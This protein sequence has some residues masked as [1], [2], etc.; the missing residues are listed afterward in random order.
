M[1]EILCAHMPYFRS[2]GHIYRATCLQTVH[3][4]YKY[5]IALFYPIIHSSLQKISQRCAEFQKLSYAEVDRKK[6][7]KVLTHDM[8]SS[9]ESDAD[10]NGKAIFSVKELLWRNERVTSFFTKLDD[11]MEKRK[12]DQAVRQ[13][14]PRVRGNKVSNRDPPEHAPS[15]AKK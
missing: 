10:D 14:K 15:W 7:E 8:I 5:L 11:S 2:P 1:D 6:W 3:A 12:S 13:S 4:C 9:D